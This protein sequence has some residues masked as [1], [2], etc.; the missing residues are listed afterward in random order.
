MAITGSLY[1]FAPEVSH[2]LYRSLEDVPARGD[3]PLAASALVQKTAGGQERRSVAIDPAG[4]TGQIRAAA[5]ARRWA[6]WR[7]WQ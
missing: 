2:I 4:R 3:A 7:S 1:L 6:S 5:A